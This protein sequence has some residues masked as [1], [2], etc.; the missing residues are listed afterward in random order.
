MFDFRQNDLKNGGQ[1]APLT[2]VFHNL[3]ANII[4]EKH[5]DKFPNFL[6]IG[7]ISNITNT[8]KDNDNLKTNIQAFDIGPGNC[9]IDE[10]IRNNS[11][12]KFDEDGLIAKSGKID[13]LILNQAIDN[14][15]FKSYKESLDVKDFDISFVRGLSLEDGCAT[16]TNFTAYIISEGIKF[17][18]EKNKSNTNNYLICGGGR[19]NTFL[20]KYI[21]DYL[22]NIKNIS[23]NSIDKYDYNGDFVESQAFGFLAIRTYLNLPITFPDTTGCKKPC[24]GGKIVKNF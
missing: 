8:V 17:S 15:H 22:A 3:L 6:N 23:L 16:L 14:F 18:I 5:K 21:A 24:I 12:K 2:P 9:L 11:N 1:G 20:I 19:K 7:G 13:K 4:F 10:W